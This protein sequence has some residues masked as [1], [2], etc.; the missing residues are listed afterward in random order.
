MFQPVPENLIKIRQ[1]IDYNGAGL[2]KIFK[3]KKFKKNFLKFWDEDKL[4]TA[5]K[6]YAKDHPYVDW[7]KLKS[8]I[9]THQFTDQTVMDK[10]FMKNLVEVMKAGKPLNNFLKEAIH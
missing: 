8:F 10:R 7:L 4:K 1:E 2:E 9:I 6:G 3:E 5:P